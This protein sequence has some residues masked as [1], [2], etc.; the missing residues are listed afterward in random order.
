M[1]RCGDRCIWIGV[2]FYLY[3]DKLSPTI[4][5]SFCLQLFSQYIYFSCLSYNIFIS[6]VSATNSRPPPSPTLSGRSSRAAVM[7][8]KSARR[9]V[10]SARSHSPVS[11]AL[12]RRFRP[13]SPDTGASGDGVAQSGGGMVV[14]AMKNF[15]YLACSLV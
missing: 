6:S 11:L 2:G 12:D 5:I 1:D 4:L 8:P 15:T 3:K 10:G 7:S 13:A 9:Q 14:A